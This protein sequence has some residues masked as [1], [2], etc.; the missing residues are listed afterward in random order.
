L[1]IYYINEP[2]IAIV[3]LGRYRE[4]GQGKEDRQG[5]QLFGS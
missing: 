5:G 4:S 3:F 1:I 2:E